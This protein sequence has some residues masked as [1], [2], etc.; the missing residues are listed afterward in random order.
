MFTYLCTPTSLRKRQICFILWITLKLYISDWW[1][2]TLMKTIP[3]HLPLNQK[4]WGP[5]T[6][7]WHRS[8]GKWCSWCPCWTISRLRATGVWCSVN[9]ERCW[10]LFNGLSLIGLVGKIA[11]HVF[12]SLVF[13][14][15]GVATQVRKKRGYIVYSRYFISCFSAF[16]FYFILL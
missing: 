14:N 13:L 2:W 3:D 15:Q 16:S 4:A 1:K 7:C 5:Q 11:L 9:Q 6:R 12:F 8:Q 10:T